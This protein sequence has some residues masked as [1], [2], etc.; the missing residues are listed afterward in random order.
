[1]ATG[2]VKSRGGG[3]SIHVGVDGVEKTERA[4]RDVRNRVARDLTALEQQAA[5]REVLP[6][7]KAFASN[8][9]VAG[10][11]V[12][13]TLVVRKQRSAPYITTS[14]RG[15]RGRAVGLQEYGGTVKTPIRPRAGRQGRDR[16][17][18]ALRIGG[19]FRSVVRTER[20][21]RAHR[22]MGRAVDDRLESFGQAVRDGIVSF[23]HDPFQT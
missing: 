3:L 4:Y 10:K 18:P 12:A 17:P 7:A 14:M 13:S 11:R 20:H 1:M 23:F 19:Q 22:F 2:S 9:S 6:A 15:V 16:R 21:Y 5:E 8:L